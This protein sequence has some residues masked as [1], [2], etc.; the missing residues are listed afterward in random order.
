MKVKIYGPERDV[1]NIIVPSVMSSEREGIYEIRM[2][3]SSDGLKTKSLSKQFAIIE[4]N[5]EIKTMQ[6][7]NSNGKCE[8]KE[9]YQ[10]CPSDC[11]YE[12]ISEKPFKPKGGYNKNY[13]F[14]GILIIIALIFLIYKNRGKSKRSSTS[15]S[16]SSIPTLKIKNT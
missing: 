8:D 4:K 2:T 16:Q 5:P 12:E 6:I 7:C 11:L 15:K 3:S 14:L 13:Y 10:N 9:S 1:K